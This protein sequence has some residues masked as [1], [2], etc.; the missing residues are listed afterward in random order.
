MSYVFFGFLLFSIIAIPA[1]YLFMRDSGTLAETIPLSV[2]GTQANSALALP[3]LVASYRDVPPDMLTY[4]PGRHSGPLRYVLEKAAHKIGYAIEW[5]QLSFSRSA[6]KMA[7]GDI[8]V[9]PYVHHKTPSR[10]SQFR[11]SVSLGRETL[12]IYFVKKKDNLSKICKIGDLAGHNIGVLAGRYY[13]AAFHAS[14][15]FKKIAYPDDKALMSA[16]SRGEVD[17]I[18]SNNKMASERALKTI[19]LNDWEYI[20]FK[21]MD[22]PDLYFLYSPRPQQTELFNRLDKALLELRKDGSIA[23]I[24]QSFSVSAPK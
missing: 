5:K 20:P 3:T 9:I 15:Q 17:L 21:Y 14:T 6:T 16:F 13:F 8:D 7:D 18:A 12:P 24:Y 1:T 19:G 22:K 10:E 11:F 2:L 4:S 23:N